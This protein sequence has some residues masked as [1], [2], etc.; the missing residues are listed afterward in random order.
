M[1][2]RIHPADGTQSHR[3]RH[4]EIN[5]VED[6]ARQN[7]GIRP[8]LL[9]PI[10]RL[11]EDGSHL[12]ASI[13]SG[14]AHVG[15]PRADA[16][17]LAQPDGVPAAE[18]DHTVGTMVPCVDDGSVRDVRGRVHG[19]LAKEACGLHTARTQDIITKRLRLSNLLGRREKQQRGKA[20]SGELGGKLLERTLTKDD[21]GR[22]GCVDEFAQQLWFSHCIHNRKSRTN[23]DQGLFGSYL[24]S[25]D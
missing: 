17:G 5:V 18:R 11:A 1:G 20:Q 21:S 15:Q 4:G 24:R 13:R 22:I 25:E 6:R 10:G 14:H 3:Q 9:D 23:E 12:T 2:N 16:D 19:G 8:R 7:L